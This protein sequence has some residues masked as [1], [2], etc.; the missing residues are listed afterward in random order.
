MRTVLLIVGIIGLLVGLL[1]VGQ[2][3]GYV[4]WPRSS[5]MINEMKWT[6]IG[7]AV[8]FIGFALVVISRRR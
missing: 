8:A 3:L 1:W 6:Y 4:H 7:A 5:F 2:G